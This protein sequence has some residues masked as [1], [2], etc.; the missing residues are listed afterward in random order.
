MAVLLSFTTIFL[1][2]TFAF[3]GAASK[4]TEGII[5][6]VIRRPFEVGDRIS[7]SDPFRDSDPFGSPGWYVEDLNIFFTT[8][9]YAATNEVSTISNYSLANA[10]IVNC[11]R[12][13]NARILFPIKVGIATPRRLLDVFKSTIENFI[14][15][16]PSKWVEV[17]LR[18]PKC[19]RC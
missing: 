13:H 17:R 10:R 6:I 14:K 11:A 19:F 15:D 18:L 12:S 4:Y 1:S 9:R 2:F 8:V 16:R 5:S 3:G 7:I